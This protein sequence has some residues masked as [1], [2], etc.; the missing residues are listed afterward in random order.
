MSQYQ[1]AVRQSLMKTSVEDC[2]SRHAALVLERIAMGGGETR[3]Y[4]C[5]DTEQ[6]ARL[7]GLLRPG[8][9]V[10]FYFDDRIRSDVDSSQ[11]RKYVENLLNVERE[12]IVGA[13]TNDLLH[14]DVMLVSDMSEC[15]EFLREHSSSTRF[16]CGLF[17]ARDN[18][19]V[20]SILVV[21]PDSDGIVRAHPY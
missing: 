9:A 10:S 11:V 16:F 1:I 5:V 12:L 19:G 8:S 15:E 2:L 14:V 3:W 18:Y 17:P 4:F 21:L 20:N 13:L 6:L 7:E